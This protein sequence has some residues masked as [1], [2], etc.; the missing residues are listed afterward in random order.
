M[1]GIDAGFLYMET[2]SSHTHTLK[3]ALL[4]PPEETGSQA[5]VGGGASPSQDV[6]KRGLVERLPRLPGFRRRIVEVPFGLNHPV[7]IEDP[8]FDIDRHIRF[9][10]VV[11]PGGP[12]EMDAA[13]SEI[14]RTPLRRDRPLWEVWI[15]EGLADGAI[16]AV[17]KIH[18]AMAD[19]R[20]AAQLFADVLRR[21]DSAAAPPDPWRPE[22]IPSR[23][24]LIRD[25]LVDR[26]RRM[27]HLPALV[28]KTWSGLR[29]VGRRMRGVK[30]RPPRPG[31]DAP[32]TPFNTSLTPRRSFASA[33][34][35]LD[36]VKLVKNAFGVTVNDVLL[37]LVAGSLRRYLQAR[38][39]LPDRSLVAEVPVSTDSAGE[40]RTSGNRTSNLFT[41]LCTT[42]A[43]AVARL[44]RVHED[45]EAAKEIHRLLGADLYE[46]W[47]DYAPPTIYRFCMRCFARWRLADRLAPA[48][49]V[50]V[51]NVPGPRTPLDWDGA[52][53]RAIHSVGPILEGLGL[54]V[55][56]W[57]YDDR[58]F[59]AALA[60][61]DR[62]DGV[63]EITDALADELAQLVDVAF[64]A[65]PQRT[66]ARTA[67]PGTI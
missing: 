47:S 56:F 64:G 52:R 43:D 67:A 15:L 24:R 46:R 36:D 58:V 62:I 59:V 66:L 37:A 39:A 65:A 21:A 20:A 5:G 55:T 18:H 28:A 42:E 14:A 9:A 57:S 51:S 4:D 48:V 16:G 10:K 49:N 33:E 6:V 30:G 44:R 61:P 11:A 60:C 34:I 41:W 38:S 31:F 13:I 63:H 1:R 22:S 7:W 27:R 19:G 32:R 2:D 45:T 53:L 8:D 23:F 25:A 12:R 40:T 26:L 50:I 3:V 29:A 54:N 17:L 35:S